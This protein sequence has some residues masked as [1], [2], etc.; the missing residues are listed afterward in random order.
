MKKG[1]FVLPVIIVVILLISACSQTTPTTSPSSSP[2]ATQPKTA[3]TSAAPATTAVAPKTTAAATTTAA[4]PGQPKYGGTLKIGPNQDAP[5]FGY[6]A[7]MIG[8]NPIRQGA[9]ALETLFRTSADGKLVPW[10][11]TGY[12]EDAAGKTITLTLRQGVKFHDGTDFNAE[13]VKWNFQQ[14]IDN[15]SPMTAKFASM[16]V[17]DPYTL[18]INLSVWDNTVSGGFNQNLGMIISPAG[19]QKNGVDWALSRPVGTG[20]FKFSSYQKDVKVVYE[21][22]DGYWQK[23]KPYLDKLEWDFYADTTSKELAFRAGEVD[24]ISTIPSQ[25][26]QNLQGAGYIVNRKQMGSGCEGVI[27][28]SGDPKSPWSNLKVRQAASYAINRDEMIVGVYNKEAEATQQYG[29]KSHWSYNPDVIGYPYDVNKAKQLLADAGYASGFK[30]TIY[31][32][33][34]PTENARFV[35]L[36]G[37]LKAIG[38]DAALKPTENA[39]YQMIYTQGQA[40]DGLVNERVSAN[41]DVVSAMTSLYGGGG[42]MYASMATPDDYLQAIQKAVTAPDFASKQKATWE[43]EKLMIDKYCLQIPW[44]SRFDQAVQQKNVRNSGIQVT[45]N[46]LY[47]PED[48]WLDK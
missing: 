23:G 7:K 36:Q 43:V 44:A 15:K 5:S 32:V 1:L 18:R 6:P 3:A 48:A 11:A 33:P 35:A 21:K 38:I 20:P 29:Y 31:C 22:F 42:K 12:K 34:D 17:V 16:E 39:A 40:W 28:S 41:P 13:A 37:Y 9:A 30:T 19:V 25:T 24:V 45:D 10:L 46:Q 14:F 2:A 27:P 47:T 4:V 8:P 26:V